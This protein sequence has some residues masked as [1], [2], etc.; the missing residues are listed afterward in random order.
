MITA[1]SC[2]RGAPKHKR[3]QRPRARTT[4]CHDKTCARARILGHLGGS[5]RYVEHTLCTCFVEMAKHPFASIISSK[6]MEAQLEDPYRM[7]ARCCGR[8][9]VMSILCT[10]GVRASSPQLQIKGRN[11]H[12]CWTTS[13]C[14]VPSPYATSARSTG[15][16]DL[17]CECLARHACE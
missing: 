5:N 17:D 3:N 11:L 16:G 7:A 1:S 12:M 14:F 13:P 4:R 2:E 10:H 15:E 9:E 6:T 8:G